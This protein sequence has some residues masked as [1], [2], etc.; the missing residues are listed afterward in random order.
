[1]LPEM[2][3]RAVDWHPYIYTVQALVITNYKLTRSHEYPEKTQLQALD[4][5]I[6][7]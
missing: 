1:M 2:P 4:F 7:K 5:N 6:T 3:Y